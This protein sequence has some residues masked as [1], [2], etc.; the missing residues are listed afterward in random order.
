MFTD[1][2]AFATG[3]QQQ[4]DMEFFDNLVAL[5]IDEPVKKR[6]RG[7]KKEPESGDDQD[8]P[9]D[10]T[11]PVKTEVSEKAKEKQEKK[12]KKEEEKAE[13][14]KEKAKLREAKKQETARKREEKVTARKNAQETDQGKENMVEENIAETQKKKRGQPP[15]SA[16]SQEEEAATSNIQEPRPK[17]TRKLKGIKNHHGGQIRPPLNTKLFPVHQVG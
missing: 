15:K 12:K 7:T 17:R 6:K 8:T 16:G 13:K 2:M 14:K 4:F 1:D 9:A 11:R 10:E 5:Q 3:E